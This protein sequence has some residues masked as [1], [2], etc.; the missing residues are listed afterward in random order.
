MCTEVLE[1][2]FAEPASRCTLSPLQSFG[3]RARKSSLGTF[4][5][6]SFWKCT[7]ST[8]YVCILARLNS[9]SIPCRS[10][11]NNSAHHISLQDKDEITILPTVTDAAATT[12]LNI[13]VIGAG[14][15]GMSFCHAMETAQQ[16]GEASRDITVVCFEKSTRPGGVWK[17]ADPSSPHNMYEELWTNGPSHNIEFPDYTFDEHFGRPVTVYMPRQEV[18]GYLIG[19]VTKNCP[20]FFE[21]YV[22]FGMQVDLVQAVGEGF[23]VKVQECATGKTE[24]L[25]FDRVVWAC[26]DNGIPKVPGSLKSVFADFP[27]R[28]IHSSDTANLES[29][30]GGKRVLLIGS[31]YSAE[32]L[33]LQA[34]KLNVEK[35]YICH[36]SE[37]GEGTATKYWPGNKVQ[38]MPLRVPI[39]AEGKTIHFAA[40]K[41]DFEYEFVA[42]NKDVVESIHDIDTVVF[43]TGYRTNKD[44]IHDDLWAELYPEY[45]LLELPDGWKMPTNTFTERLGDVEPAK[46]LWYYADMTQPEIYQGLLIDNPKMMYLLTF[47][48]FLPLLSC[49]VTAWMLMRYCTGALSIPSREE[50]RRLNKKRALE[51]FSIPYCRFYMDEKYF[52]ALNEAKFTSEEWKQED[53]KFDTYNFNL[54]AKH[55]I[56]GKYLF[57]IGCGDKL[58]EIGKKFFDYDFESSYHRTKLTPDMIAKEPWRTFR[59]YRNPEVFASV[60]TGTPAVAL[61]KPWFEIGVEEEG[62]DEEKKSI[63]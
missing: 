30:F 27:G 6:T 33:A 61:T 16:A 37:R 11:P 49:D 2:T 22:R 7:S 55:M 41:P 5:K 46:H 13:A 15:A 54:L 26:G 48:S 36:R 32:D 28:A 60:H 29:D 43:C 3:R 53:D 63:M 31:G 12:M 58:N 34:C 39:R 44:M 20:D 21:K 56:A 42:A 8:L 45:D 18:L 57:S 38:V 1:S 17:A 14:P 10:H 50:M 4:Y 19:R 59:D 47:D 25:Q 35:V 9:N 24:K 62:E 51:E 52:V 40:T 23:A